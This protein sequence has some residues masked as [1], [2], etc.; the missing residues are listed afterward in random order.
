MVQLGVLYDEFGHNHTTYRTTRGVE[1]NIY[2]LNGDARSARAAKF[3]RFSNLVKGVSYSFAGAGVMIDGVGVYN[4]YYSPDPNAFT[5]HPAKAGL[6]TEM[7]GVGLYGTPIGW[8]AA[9][10]YFLID[11]TI[12]WDNAL[13]SRERII[14]ENQKLGIDPFDIYG[15]KW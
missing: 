9:G 7:T 10:G 8:G 4:Y 6:N 1:K 15:S 2:K 14:G 5:V 3:A 13:E 12:G 11:A